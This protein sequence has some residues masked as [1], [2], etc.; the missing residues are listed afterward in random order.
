MK[1]TNRFLLTLTFFTV[2]V[3]ILSSCSEPIEETDP[4]AVNDPEKIE[5]AVSDPI[6]EQ[7]TLTDIAVDENLRA[8]YDAICN[9]QPY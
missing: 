3:F 4:N 1:T 9:Y 6:R 8:A 5:S 7:P 2:L